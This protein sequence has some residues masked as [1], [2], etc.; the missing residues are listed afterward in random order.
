MTLAET[1][2]PLAD[3]VILRLIE[4]PKQS[5][6]GVNLP[7]TAALPS[8]EGIVVAMGPGELRCVHCGSEGK[9]K[10]MPEGLAVGAHV[11]FCHWTGSVVKHNGEDLFLVTSKDIVAVVDE[12][13][14]DPTV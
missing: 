5:T 10:P 4:K 9:R 6:G 13:K 14:D 1:T 7:D 12:V 8:Q 11:I 2:R 3:N